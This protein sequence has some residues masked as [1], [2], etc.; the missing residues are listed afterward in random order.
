MKAILKNIDSLEEVEI[1]VNFEDLRLGST[2]RGLSIS[3][4]SFSNLD[5]DLIVYAYR[6]PILRSL[7]TK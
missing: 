6:K 1:K 3:G 4:L 5:N 2:I 7:C